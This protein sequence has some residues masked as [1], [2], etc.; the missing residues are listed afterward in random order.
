[1]SAD[2]LNAPSWVIRPFAVGTQVGC[3]VAKGLLAMMNWGRV[4]GGSACGQT[5]FVAYD[6]RCTHL[7]HNLR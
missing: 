4:G 6:V 3:R 5:N 1:M 2:V 7:F